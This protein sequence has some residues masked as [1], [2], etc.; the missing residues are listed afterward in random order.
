MTA[1]L[2]TLLRLRQYDVDRSQS[3]LAAAILLEQAL[4]ER[5][6]DLNRQCEQQRAELSTLTREGQL[7]IDALRLRQEHLKRLNDQQ[8]AVR[9]ELATAGEAI[10]LQQTSLVAA[11]QRRQVVEKLRERQ[12]QEAQQQSRRADARELDEVC[13]A[14]S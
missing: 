7:N 13:R 4:K 14:R 5:L 1:Q 6:L 9:A 8:S 2:N 11:D 12:L 3:Q 10:Q